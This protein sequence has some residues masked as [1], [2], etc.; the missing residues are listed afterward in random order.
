MAADD[1]QVRFTADINSIKVQIQNLEKSI[2]G[3]QVAADKAGKEMTSSFSKA[4]DA[5]GNSLRNIALGIGAAFSVSAIQ[6]FAVASVKAFAEAEAQT[7]QLRFAVEKVGKMSKSVFDEL[8]RQSKELAKITFFDDEDIQTVQKLF[9][10]VG[11]GADQ[12][13]KITPLIL[14]LA[15]TT[16]TDLTTATQK[17]I[18]AING[19][20]RGLK[21]VGINFQN[22]GTKVGNYN[23]LIEGLTRLQGSA[24]EA[25]NTTEGA[26]K[27]NAVEIENLQESIGE[28][29]APSILKAKKY[30]LELASTLTNILFPATASDEINNLKVTLDEKFKS[31]SIKDLR[32]EVESYTNAIE[33]NE[34][35]IEK[36]L[37]DRAAG[38]SG[39]PVE[40]KRLEDE[41]AFFKNSQAAIRLILI[42]RYNQEK[43]VR[44]NA[45]SLTKQ[46]AEKEVDEVKKTEEKKVEVIKGVQEDYI[47][48]L[49][50]IDPTKQKGGEIKTTFSGSFVQSPEE[51]KRIADENLA[52]TLEYVAA[53]QDVLG[54][55]FDFL[56][57]QNQAELDALSAKSERINE[58]FDEEAAAL[59][60][61]NERGAISDR[62]YEREKDA[63]AEKRKASDKKLAQEEKKLKQQQAETAKAQAIFEVIINTAVAVMKAFK[64]GGLPLSILVGAA[65]A[66][67]LA[68][69]L[70]TPIP[71][72]KDGNPFV[73]D[74]NA[75]QG[76]DTILSWLDRG[77]RVVTADNNKKHWDKF[78]AIESG[79]FD[80]YVERFYVQP[81]LSVAKKEFEQRQNAGFAKNVADSMFMNFS[82]LT[83]YEADRIR[84]K[85]MEIRNTDEIAV[86]IAETLADKLPKY[87]GKLYN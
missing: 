17:A 38:K 47:N 59:E 63:L 54:G 85:G 19:Q 22:T 3:T 48:S 64:D 78:E 12:I 9:V 84:R 72:F 18:A 53:A 87:Y 26:L 27:K 74:P 4:G 56:N 1:V 10:Q 57:Q 55:F 28:R 71:K 13:K 60:K 11:L 65:G 40:K 36:I 33:E 16:G 7:N 68:T 43:Q 61:K 73:D 8:I 44:D 2:A 25:L 23:E 80:K 15:A 37:N 5:I 58:A 81:Q 6:Q 31:T 32:G 69:I 66:V 52:I 51:L 75:P 42:D 41:I 70:S 39:D 21:D 82:G 46:D 34:K 20:T 49:E 76:R 45:N 83:A 24:T 14:D 30:L 86:K 67:Q 50:K 29:L 77:E 79:N 62:Q 35:A